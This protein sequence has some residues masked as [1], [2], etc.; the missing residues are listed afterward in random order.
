MKDL[1]LQIV[2]D[3]LVYIGDYNIMTAQDEISCIHFMK[4]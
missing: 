3:L 4:F 1:V 2:H